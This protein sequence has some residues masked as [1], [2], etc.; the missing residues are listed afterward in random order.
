[1]NAMPTSGSTT[2]IYSNPSPISIAAG[3]GTAAIGASKLGGKK[4]GGVVEG[5]MRKGGLAALAV[6]KLH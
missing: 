3:L 5:G 2:S 1:M 4:G 6:S